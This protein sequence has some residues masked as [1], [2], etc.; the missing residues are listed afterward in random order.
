MN[1]RVHQ[2]DYM[3]DRR[4]NGSLGLS[5]CH[6]FCIFQ[7]GVSF[8]DITGVWEWELNL[9]MLDKNPEIYGKAPYQ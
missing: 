5:P 3:E 4:L 9:G 2:G 8:L 6:L 1:G 7:F